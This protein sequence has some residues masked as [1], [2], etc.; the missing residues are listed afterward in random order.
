MVQAVL[1]DLDGTLV[2]SRDAVV[3]AVNELFNEIGRPPIRADEVIP[4][5]GVGL[6]PLL[7]R[8]VDKPES[9]IAR[10]R[11]IY[12]SGFQ[13]RTS[14][15]RGAEE[16][17]RLLKETGVR[18]GIATNRSRELSQVIVDYFGLTGY[19]DA[20]VGQGGDNSYLKPDPKLIFEA[21]RALEVDPEKTIMAGD[22]E[23]D[24]ETGRNA[25]CFTI[26][27]DHEAGNAPTEAD[28][29]VYELPEILKFLDAV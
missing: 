7:G 18:T 29:V 5:I 22:T 9:Y 4:L 10:Y 2:D 28:A 19:L 27:V 16:V 17:L 24:V 25:G 12:K 1:F 26:K 23:I 21:C 3:W 13:K 14:V 11:D 20:L 15:Y 6:V 8:F